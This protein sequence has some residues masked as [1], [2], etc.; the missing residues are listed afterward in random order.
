[1]ASEIEVEEIATVTS[2]LLSN[3]E[4]LDIRVAE[5]ITLPLIICK[6]MLEVTAKGHFWQ[7][8]MAYVKDVSVPF[9]IK[10]TLTHQPCQ[11][12]YRMLK[13]LGGLCQHEKKDIIGCLEDSVVLD[14]SRAAIALNI[15]VSDVI[16]ILKN[17]PGAEITKSG[18]GGLREKSGRWQK[19]PWV[20]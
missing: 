18:R 20:S 16:N 7:E 14:K 15:A 6:K 3:L 17:T 4:G 5:D 12:A 19:S 9:H 11:A 13:E 10:T 1:M 8:V 2:G